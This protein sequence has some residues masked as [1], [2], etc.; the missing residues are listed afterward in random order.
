VAARLQ[1]A[2]TPKR[3]RLP[4]ILIKL[5]GEYG[6][7]EAEQDA[8]KEYRMPEGITARVGVS[9]AFRVV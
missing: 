3:K 1:V 4:V 2:P 8:D 6:P 5:H 7:L 9:A